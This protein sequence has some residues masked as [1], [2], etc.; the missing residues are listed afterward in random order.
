MGTTLFDT[1]TVIV[2]TVAHSDG[3]GVK[4]YTVI[5]TDDV[6]ITSGDH[7]PVTGIGLF[8][9]VAKISGITLR[10]YGPNCSNVGKAGGITLMVMV[11]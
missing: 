6:L 5:P 3:E 8:E 2:A 10:Q 11:T 9:L 7:I 1:S 4:V